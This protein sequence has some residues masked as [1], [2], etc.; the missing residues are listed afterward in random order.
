MPSNEVNVSYLLNKP[1]HASFA[2]ACYETLLERSIEPGELRY[3][4]HMLHKGLSRKGF[5]YW[6]SRSPEFGQRFVIKDISSYR[7]SCYWYKGIEKLSRALHQHSS[8]PRLCLTQHPKTARSPLGYPVPSWETAQSQEAFSFNTE[9]CALAACQINLLAASLSD[10]LQSLSWHT[11]GYLAPELMPETNIRETTLPKDFF[12]ELL[13][14]G[15]FYEKCPE[16]QHEAGQN[17][18]ITSPAAIFRLFTENH[19]CD[20]ARR[21]NDTLLFTMPALPITTKNISIVWDSSWTDP[22]PEHDQTISRWLSG[23]TNQGTI[24]LLN[25]DTAY[26]KVSIH[27]T[28]M[29]YFPDSMVIITFGNAKKSIPFSGTLC[30]VCLDLW[31]NPGYN[32][33]SLTYAGPH[34]EFASGPCHSVKFALNNFTL[35]IHGESN[36]A[37]NHALA[38][39]VHQ[40]SESAVGNGYFPYLLPDSLI[41]SAL[42]R[43]GFFE[44]QAISVSADY[45]VRKLATTRYDYPKDEAG[46]HCF[47]SFDDEESSDQNNSFSSV[48]AYIARRT[49]GLCRESFLLHNHNTDKEANNG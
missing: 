38:A 32:Q 36:H 19:L 24:T 27:F 39:S 28:L 26:Q 9:Y 46:Q 7:L 25:L 31:L 22:L 47:Y 48:T 44:V 14:S 15:S 41:R 33:I 5:I 8:G 18:F 23:P 35:Y 30:P 2:S 16:T 20:L 43:S 13:D 17:F 10:T 29:T 6:V 3:A 1:N 40:L 42:H 34:A 12:R 37:K 4:V 45:S 49:S 21:T 11:V